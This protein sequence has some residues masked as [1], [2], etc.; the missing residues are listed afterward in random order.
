MKLFRPSFLIIFTVLLL[1]V[2][3][4]SND[5]SGRPIK[6]FTFINQDG[7]E[8]GLEDMKG[9]VWI[10]DFIF[11]NCTTVCPPM[12]MNMTEIQ[13]QIK[14]K[15]YD[16]VHIVSF[17]VDPEVDSPKVLKEYAETFEADLDNWQFLTGYSMEEIAEFAEKNFKAPAFKPENDDQVIHG[18]AFYVINKEG[19]IVKDFSGVEDV[20]FS[21]IMK[22]VK[23]LR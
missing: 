15:G 4:C 18:S 10:A 2:S 8:F 12:T 3:A 1:F 13:K 17:T 14:E 11:T 22:E 5:K 9:K 7:K 23:R 16:D 21:H 6:D 20:Q 19:E